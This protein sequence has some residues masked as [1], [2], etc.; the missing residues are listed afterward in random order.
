MSPG[1][2]LCGRPLFSVVV[3]NRTG[4]ANDTEQAHKEAERPQYKVKIQPRMQHTDFFDYITLMLVTCNIVNLLRFLLSSVASVAVD[5][6]RQLDVSMYLPSN[7]FLSKLDC[8]EFSFFFLKETLSSKEKK[9]SK[10]M[11]LKCSWS[12]FVLWVFALSNMSMA[13]THLRFSHFTI[14]SWMIADFRYCFKSCNLKQSS[15]WSFVTHDIQRGALS[16]F[17]H[18]RAGIAAWLFAQAAI[19]SSSPPT[20]VFFFWFNTQLLTVFTIISLFPISSLSCRHLNLR[21]FL[22][23]FTLPSLLLSVHPPPFFL[24]PA[25]SRII[26]LL[27]CC[28]LKPSPYSPAAQH[29]SSLMLLQPCAIQ[30]PLGVQN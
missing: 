15:V 24:F 26:S 21:L 16:A 7:T 25:I 23:P 13:A 8:R 28:W 18:F 10:T 19:F 5:F 27:N 11:Y 3:F 22:P 2:S 4:F 6:L 20:V 12:N 14:R 29:S 1:S 17:S 30:L 9:K